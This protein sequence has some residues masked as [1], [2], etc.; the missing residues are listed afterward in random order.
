[1][2]ID[3]LNR[4]LKVAKPQIINSDQGCQ[5]TSGK[6]K[7]FL[8]QHGIRQS[9][10]GKSRWADNVIV[11]YTSRSILSGNVAVSSQGCSVVFLIH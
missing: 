4:A 6:Y 8:R 3:A 5:F 10:D 9:M 7:D 2:V 11:D 1:M